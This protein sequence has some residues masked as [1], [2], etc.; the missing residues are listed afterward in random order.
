MS[1]GNN[2]LK[3]YISNISILIENNKQGMVSYALRTALIWPPEIYCFLGAVPANSIIN[4]RQ[5]N[6]M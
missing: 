4:I 5:L 6:Y 1:T 3:I 2:C